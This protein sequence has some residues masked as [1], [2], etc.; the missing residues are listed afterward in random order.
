MCGKGEKLRQV[1]HCAGVFTDVLID[2][3]TRTHLLDS[4]SI[5]ETGLLLSKQKYPETEIVLLQVSQDDAIDRKPNS[6][7]VGIGWGTKYFVCIYTKRMFLVM[8]T[9]LKLNIWLQ[10]PKN[11]VEYH[12]YQRST[13]L[14]QPNPSLC[15]IK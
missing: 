10:Q 1:K 6:D 4:C 14:L 9:T 12:T 8:A 7:F 2:Y 11:L 13:W 5:L 3:S 15:V